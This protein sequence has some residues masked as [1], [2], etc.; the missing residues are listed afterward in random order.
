VKP[1]KQVQVHKIF[2]TRKIVWRFFAH[3]LRKMLRWLSFVDPKAALNNKRRAAEIADKPVAIATAIT[4]AKADAADAMDVAVVV[5]AVEAKVAITSKDRAKAVSVSQ[6][7]IPKTELQ[8]ALAK[9]AAAELKV[10]HQVVETKEEATLP[11]R[12]FD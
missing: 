3:K 10:V 9:E 7:V 1:L 4:I 6:N 12:Q 2:M 8:R 5:D 11:S